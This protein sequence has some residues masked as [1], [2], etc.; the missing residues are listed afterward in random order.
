MEAL[1]SEAW[2]WG[3]LPHG[4]PCP[5][6]GGDTCAASLMAH[7]AS[8]SRCV[9]PARLTA[10]PPPRCGAPAGPLEAAAAAEAAANAPAR[11]PGAPPPRGA[12]QRPLRAPLLGPGAAAAAPHVAAA[13]GTAPPHEDERQQ[14]PSPRA[15]APRAV[16]AGEDFVVVLSASGRLWDSRHMARHRHPNVKLADAGAALR[17]VVITAVAAGERAARQ[18]LRPCVE[19]PRRLGGRRR[20]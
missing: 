19:G 14:Q 9:A 13:A 4:G 5:L 3:L 10:A 12:R 18:R 8:G 6:P 11:L 15:A 7:T 16:A 17:G 1:T 20:R 2:V